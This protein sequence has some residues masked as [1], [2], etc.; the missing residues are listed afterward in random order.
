MKNTHLLIRYGF[1]ASDTIGRYSGQ[2]SHA[3]KLLEQTL[4][5]L[6]ITFGNL[7]SATEEQWA[8][9]LK[10]ASF[11]IERRGGECLVNPT[12]G[13]LPLAD[14]DLYMRGIC[15]WMNE[16]GIYTIHSC[17]GHGRR[18]PMVGALNHPTRKQI[19]LLRLLAPEGMTVLPRNKT[20]DLDCGGHQELLLQFAERLYEVAAN[21][22]ALVRYE[23]ENFKQRLIGLLSITGA[24]GNEGL[25]RQA[26]RG[27]LRPLADDLYVDRAGNVCA[28]IYCGEGPTVLLSAHMDIYQ[29]LEPERRIIQDGTILRSTEG[30]LGADDRAGIAVILEI[31]S[32]IH[33]T[34][35]NGTLKVAFTVKEE[36]GLIG[37]QKLD[38]CFLAD[39]D[40]AIV[41]DRRGTR[42]IVTSCASVI[43]FCPEEYGMLFEEAGRLAGMPDWRTTTGG[44]SDAKVLSQM[45]GIPSVN[46]SAGYTY[47][48]TDSE[49]VDYTATYETLK[50]IESVLHHQLVVPQSDG[51]YSLEDIV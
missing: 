17:E 1:K 32:K 11:Q 15:R 38:P 22:T 50:L 2:P 44:S 19:E 31:A 40:A 13:E 36:I 43:P 4:A 30:I 24:S 41:V 34:N 23:A 46:L 20:I 14:M 39:V 21:P 47:E 6:G 49:T 18:L 5:N 45:F 3:S 25:I 8:A 48:H 35:F 9:A 12:L 7:A 33:R 29:E 27:K 28:A 37:S 16:L 26:V 42:D 10:A 51:F